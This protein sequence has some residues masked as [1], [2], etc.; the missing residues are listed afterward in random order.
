MAIVRWRRW[1]LLDEARPWNFF[2]EIA[3]LRRDIEQIFARWQSGD[4]R[5]FLPATDVVTKDKDV[6]IQMELPGLDPKK[7]LEVKV[8]GDMLVVSGRHSEDREVRDENYQL[9]ERHYGSFYRSIPLPEGLGPEAITA[10]YDNGVLELTLA[11]A[12]QIAQVAPKRIEVKTGKEAKTIEA[13]A[14]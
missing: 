14:A 6:V 8:E 9:R 10:V 2:D 11:G 5:G 13:K 7:D 4:Q 3:G 1:N 12:A